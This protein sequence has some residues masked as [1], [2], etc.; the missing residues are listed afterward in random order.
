MSIHEYFNRKHTEWSITGFLNEIKVAWQE[1]SGFLVIHV[2]RPSNKTNTGAQEPKT[3][4]EIA[5]KWENERTHKQVHIHQPTINGTVTAIGIVGTGTI[6]GGTFG[7]ETSKK[8]RNQEDYHEELQRKQA[9]IDG[10]NLQPIYNVQVPPPRVVTPPHPRNCTFDEYVDGECIDDDDV[11]EESQPINWEFDEPMPT[12]LSKVIERQKSLTSQTDLSAR[13]KSP[14]WWRIIDASDPNIVSDLLTEADMSELIAVFSSALNAGHPTEGWTILE[15]IAERCLQ[16]LSKVSVDNLAFLH[17]VAFYLINECFDSKLDNDQLC[18]IGKIVQLEG[19]HGA[20]LEIQKM[21][22][23]E[24]LVKEE[25]YLNPDVQYIL[26]LIRFTCEMLAKNIPQRKNS[27]RDID[28]FIK[29][30]IFSGE[31]VSRASRD[32]RA[33]AVDAPETTEGY[34]M[35]WMFTKHD[36][37]KDLPYG[38]EFSLCERT[39]SRIDN[40]R[41]ILSNTLKAQKTLRDMHRTLIETISAEGGGMLSKQVLRATT[42]L[43]MPGFLSHCFFIRAFLVVYIGGFYSSVNLADLDIPTTYS[44][45][46]SVIRISRIMLQVKKLLNLTVCRFKL[47]KDRAEKEKFAGGRVIVNARLQE[48]RS[49]QKAK[50]SKQERPV[51]I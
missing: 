15:P 13:F 34:H 46:G 51:G 6:S 38:R 41:K 27:E 8:K 19:T 25:D 45:L 7:V 24:L 26:D 36:L 4:Q 23:P 28:I 21:E 12:W 3:D 48:Y 43:L 16:T 14:I 40:E 11:F 10:E 47:M 42:K 31:M 33:V 39:G 17:F 37:A 49:P 1:S 30:H 32:R 44:E 2:F 9:R 50:N 18:K 5:K 35:D 22:K 29:R 20:I